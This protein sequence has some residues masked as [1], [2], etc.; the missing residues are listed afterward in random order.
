MRGFLVLFCSMAFRVRY[1]VVGNLKR[2]EVVWGW[3]SII[4]T[5]C[6]N[7]SVLRYLT[8]V[9]KVNF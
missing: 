1:T 5:V 7:V 4:E 9:R 3:F 6:S 2:L 8:L